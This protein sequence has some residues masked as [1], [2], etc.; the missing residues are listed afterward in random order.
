[1]DNFNV[2][3]VALTGAAVF[4]LVAP[5]SVVAQENAQ[6]GAGIQHERGMDLGGEDIIVTARRS[7][8]SLSS[9]PVAITAVSGAGLV[10]Q[11]V[12][13]FKDLQKITPSLSL[14]TSNISPSNLSVGLRGQGVTEPLIYVDPSIGYY[15]NGVSLPNFNGAGMSA[16]LDIDRVEVLKGPQGTLYGRNTTGGSLNVFTNMPVDRMQVQLSGGLGNYNYAQ[17]AGMVNVPL[18]TDQVMLRVNAQY[19]TRSTFGRN[20][21]TGRGLGGDLNNTYFRGQLRF[22]P[23]E[24]VTVDLYADYA[25]T[26]TTG[27]PWRARGITLTPPAS[28]SGAALIRAQTGVATLA[29]AAALYLFRPLNASFWDTYSNLDNGLPLHYRDYSYSRSRNINLM[30]TINWDFSDELS[31]KSNT[32]YKRDMRQ[33]SY[34]FDGSPYDILTIYTPLKA[35]SLNQEFQFSGLLVDD[36]LNYV[37]GLYYSKLWGKDGTV[38]R[39]LVPLNPLVPNVSDGSVDNKS[40]A[41]YAQI[42]YKITDAFSL[43]GGLRYTEDKRQLVSH[44][45]AG[46]GGVICNVPVTLREPTGCEGRFSTSFNNTS[47]TLSAEYKP[48]TDVLIFVRNATGYRS[49]GF[50]LRATT[51]EAFKPFGPE[52]VVDYELGVKFKALDGRLDVAVDLYHSIYDDIQRAILVPVATGAGITQVVQNAAKGKVDGVEAQLRFA[53][54]REFTLNLSGAYTDARY[55]R[56]VDGI[57]KDLSNQPFPMTSKWQ[58]TVAATYQPWSELSASLNWS[59]RSDVAYTPESLFDGQNGLPDLRGQKAYGLLDGRVV[60]RPDGSS[61]EIAVW[62]RNL[63]NK[64]YFSAGFAG[65]TS[66]GI[67]SGV[68]GSP[69]T[70]GVTFTKRID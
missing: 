42:S 30:G 21:L 1:M 62:G 56:Y 68:V 59:W 11:N 70:F 49:G 33:S 10:R 57:G 14:S 65:E 28:S 63:S 12:V 20:L 26:M 15:L 37:A 22:V 7:D 51:V 52:K 17:V 29:E 34:D 19:E 43:S 23:A 45:R 67:N 41:A 54:T 3:S 64:K 61:L 53:P 47:Y 27:N 46:P 16:F 8:E 44:N 24:T 4:A 48:A 58:Y 39:A 60:Y 36:R 55:K 18:K 40:Y 31:V 5:T 66:F 13:E 25:Y 9:V 50:N 6:A 32:G 35:Q 38:N 69:R 2:K